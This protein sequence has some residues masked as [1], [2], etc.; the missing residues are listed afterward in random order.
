MLVRGSVVLEEGAH[1]S[2][3]L[4]GSTHESDVDLVASVNGASQGV[5]MGGESKRGE[6]GSRQYIQHL[7]RGRGEHGVWRRLTGDDGRWLKA[8]V[9]SE[10]STHQRN[11]ATCLTST[12]PRA[13]HGP[14]AVI[15]LGRR[16]WL[17]AGTRP[18]LLPGDLDI[19]RPAD[20]RGRAPEYV[21][22][23]F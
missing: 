3:S 19:G 14:R 16:T 1:G 10:T 20:R 7:L 4:E 6:G 11:G 9:G 5:A 17:S 2:R 21:S 8:V 15:L 12:N 13:N 18:P 22:V 23:G